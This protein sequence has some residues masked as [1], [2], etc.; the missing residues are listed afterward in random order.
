[1]SYA[2]EALPRGFSDLVGEEAAQGVWAESMFRSVTRS[3]GF[4]PVTVA[5][6]GYAETFEQF[7]SA[8]TG[9]I[10]AFEDL[11]GRRL[12]LTADSLVAVLRAL[13]GSG[14]LTGGASALG[15]ACVP[16]A[17]YRRKRHRGWSQAVAVICNEADELAADLTLLRLWAELF[18]VLGPAAGG[19]L[20]Y[21]D[22]GVLDAIA[23]DEG[24]SPAAARNALHHRR[25]GPAP[26][27]GEPRAAEPA[28]P[29]P[30]G[31]LRRLDRLSE[32]CRGL[33]PR[34]APD[35]VAAAEP[36][37]GER[38]AHLRTVLAIAHELGVRVEFALDWEHA[39][40]YQA[41]LCFLARTGDGRTLG[42]GGGYHHMVRTLD[43]GLSSCWSTSASV[44]LLAELGPVPD[45]EC[46]HLMRMP[47]ADLRTF[48]AVARRLRGA[49]YDVLEHWQ[50]RRLGRQLRRV[51]ARPS[52]WFALV[53]EKEA[54]SG[55]LTLQNAAA[56]GV[57]RDLDLNPV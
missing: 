15:A 9:R 45:A 34:E 29:S 52:Q 3:F 43:I 17:R 56:T 54:A 19:R 48:M 10:F 5:P 44:N 21:C 8:A 1:M 18:E 36:V 13:A 12:A 42:D 26:E 25:R 41:G 53:G 11:S 14:R 27:A 38:M 20:E 49:G 4:A 32:L 23:A 2:F 33:P 24:L 35:R 30:A 37:T 46:V 51:P 28:P 47:S 22:Y 39:P 7:G 31:F 50:P 55:R 57:T 6:V 16:I 40:E